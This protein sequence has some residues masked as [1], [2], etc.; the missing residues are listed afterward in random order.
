[1]KKYTNTTWFD[2]RKKPTSQVQD[3]HCIALDRA[4]VLSFIFYLSTCVRFFGGE[5]RGKGK[6]PIN[7]DD[8]WLIH[9]ILI[10]YHSNVSTRN[11]SNNNK[12]YYVPSLYHVF[13]FLLQLI[14]P[15]QFLFNFLFS[16]ILE[17]HETWQKYLQQEL[18]GNIFEKFWKYSTDI[19][20][21]AFQMP[22]KLIHDIR[23]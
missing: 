10:L 7:D 12:Y 17:S 2:S 21:K 1:M 16:T 4:R 15:T 23:N 14:N 13:L 22:I 11:K 18:E 20:K 5:G 8:S 9:Y 6:R 19:L 3:K